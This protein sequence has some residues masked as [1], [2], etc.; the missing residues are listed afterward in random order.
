MNLDKIAFR[1]KG[2]AFFDRAIRALR[3][4]QVYNHTLWSYAVMHND[5]QALR[6]FLSNENRMVQNLGMYFD[7]SLLTVDPIE[8]AW[9]YH[10]EY[11]P[12]VN[13]RT[14]Q[15]GKQRTIL[16]P[17]FHRQY[18]SFMDV[19]ANH[20]QL[21]DDDHLIV[22]YYMLLQDRISDAMDHFSQVN[23]D[24]IQAK[25][26]YDYCDAYLDMYRSK[27]EEAAAKAEKWADYPVLHWRNRFKAI[28]AQVEEIR[29]GE[30]AVVD[31]ENKSERQTSMA[32]QAESFDFEVEA[33]KGQLRY[34]NLEQVAINYYEMDIELLF[35]RSPFAQD[36]LDGFSMI[37]PNLTRTVK[38]EP[39]PGDEA[40]SHEFELPAELANKNVLVEV[41]AGDQAKSKPYFANSLNVQMIETFGQLQVT[42]KEHARPLPTTYVK[43]Y[44]RDAN[45]IVKFHKD[46]YTDLR[47]RFDYVSQSNNTLDGISKYSIL[48]LHPEYGAIVRQA[49][50]PKE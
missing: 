6:E 41:V 17:E 49:D 16:N 14:H 46:G 15:L 20:S 3:D 42:D 7:S 34:Q 33:G 5:V 2:K 47:G 44:S 48:V 19:L 27:P 28:L 32:S 43:V 35:S 30:T 36:E 9:Y 23:Q 25:M 29:G 50:P 12:L 22:T 21:Q 24:N 1:M 4:R 18:H 11:W 31:D 37:R 40:Q 38:L 45:G 10:R 26:Q 8:R 39:Q 13:A